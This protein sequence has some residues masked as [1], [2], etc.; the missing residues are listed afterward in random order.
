MVLLR[1]YIAGVAMDK[2]FAVARLG[3]TCMR[4]FTAWLMN[5]GSFID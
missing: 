4:K 3:A 5:N 2:A 1:C